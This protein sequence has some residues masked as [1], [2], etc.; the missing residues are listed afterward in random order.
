[1][2]R[3]ER[4]R[5]PHLR[6]CLFTQGLEIQP[7]H[8]ILQIIARRL[9]DILIKRTRGIFAE[10]K[11]CQ[12]SRDIFKGVAAVMDSDVEQGGKAKC[13]GAVFLGDGGSLCILAPETVGIH[14][15]VGGPAFRVAAGAKN[16]AQRVRGERLEINALVKMAGIPLVRKRCIQLKTLIMLG[17]IDVNHVVEIAVDCGSQVKGRT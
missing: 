4:K 2:K 1:M 14:F 7:A 12:K 16:T 10:P 8:I 11:L 9:Q 17:W 13:E 3:F 5:I 15:H 6:F